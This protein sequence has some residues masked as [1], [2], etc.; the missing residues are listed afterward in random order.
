MCGGGEDNAGNPHTPSHAHT[1][2]HT[3]THARTHTHVQLLTHL[4]VNSDINGRWSH[5]LNTLH[6]QTHTHTHTH[7]I[8]K[9]FTY[10][11]NGNSIPLPSP[12]RRMTRCLF[13][14]PCLLP[15]AASRP[16]LTRAIGDVSNVPLLFNLQKQ[17]D[18]VNEVIDSTL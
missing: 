18:H 15:L 4:Q 3:L 11:Q 6:T 17:G 9:T 14:E 2:T 10:Q 12:Y 13:L 8:H 1:H 5:A 16:A 7:S